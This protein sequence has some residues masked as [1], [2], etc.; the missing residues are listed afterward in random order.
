MPP[1]KLTYFNVPGR[2]E[3]SRM[4]FTMAG[5]PFEDKRIEFKEWPEMKKG[6][7][8]HSATKVIYEMFAN[9]SFLISLDLHQLKSLY[10]CK[11]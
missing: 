3:V 6:R 1:Y 5:V 7:N 9:F 11:S 10:L 4:L 8:S 2:G